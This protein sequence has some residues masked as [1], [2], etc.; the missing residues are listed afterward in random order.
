MDLRD[1]QHGVLRN[2]ELFPV[3]YKGVL[4]IPKSNNIQGRKN[5]RAAVS[6]DILIKKYSISLPKEPPSS[7]PDPNSQLYPHTPS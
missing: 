2:I 4:R 6:D 1:F 3:V 5:N 7:Y